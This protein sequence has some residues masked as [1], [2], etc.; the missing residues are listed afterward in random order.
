MVRNMQRK[1]ATTFTV[2]LEQLERLT[3]EARRSG[4]NRSVIVREAIER[5]LQRRRKK[6]HQPAQVDGG[7]EVERQAVA[8]ETAGRT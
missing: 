5:E 3:E 7:L 4:E 8:A 2:E 1:I 6:N